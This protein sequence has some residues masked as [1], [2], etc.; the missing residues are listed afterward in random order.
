LSSWKAL[1]QLEGGLHRPAVDGVFAQQE[2]VGPL[3]THVHGT[4]ADTVPPELVLRV[5]TPLLHR[6]GGA[7]EHAVVV[8]GLVQVDQFRGIGVVDQELP[9]VQTLLDQLVDDGQEQGAVGAGTDRHPFVGDRRVAGAH[10]VDGDEAP[11][12]PC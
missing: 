9:V 10:R 7:D 12:A 2:G 8:G 1:E 6:P 5:E 11:A 4:V 3:G